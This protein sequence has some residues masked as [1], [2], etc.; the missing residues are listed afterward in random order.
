MGW[1]WAKLPYR[2]GEFLSLTSPAITNY[3]PPYREGPGVG[4]SFSGGAGGGSFLFGRS[5]G[6]LPLPREGWGGVVF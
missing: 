5:E 1:R 4:L 2:G 6:G 3:S